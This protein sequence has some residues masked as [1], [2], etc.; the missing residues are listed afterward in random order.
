M[1]ETAPARALEEKKSAAERDLE[2][3]KLAAKERN[4]SAD[5]AFGEKGGLLVPEVSQKELDLKARQATVPNDNSGSNNGVHKEGESSPV[6]GLCDLRPGEDP[7]VLDRRCRKWEREKGKEPLTIRS[8][9]SS[10]VKGLCDLRPGEDPVVLDR[11]CRKR[12]REK[13]KVLVVDD[14]MITSSSLYLVQ[15]LSC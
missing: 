14:I 7:V 13:G 8:G 4:A 2:K 15:F 3:K 12:E 10:L 9:E 11:R 1:E 5:L 6:K